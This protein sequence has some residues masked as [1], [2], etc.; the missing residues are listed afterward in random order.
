MSARDRLPRAMPKSNKVVISANSSWNLVNYRAP[1]IRALIEDGH[2]VLAAVP[3]DD[4]IPQLRALG[5]GIEPIAIQPRGLSPVGDLRLLLSYRSLMRRVAPDAFLGF[6]VKPN[7]YGTM[8]AAS[9][10]VPSINTITGLG[11]GFLSGAALQHLISTLYRAAMRKSDRVFFHNQ[12]DLD[13]F[14]GKGLIKRAQGAVVAGSGVDL[15]RF[16]AAEPPNRGTDPTF[17][18]IGRFLKDKGVGEFIEAA[19]DLRARFPSAR[20][21][22]IGSIEDHPKAI[23]RE[24]VETA[25]QQ[26]IVELI[27]TT[28][29]VRPFIADADCV[30]LPSYREGLPRV[31]LEASAMA[32]PVI[33]TDVPGCRQAVV[34]GKTGLLCDSRSASALADA[35]S[36]FAAMTAGER[37]AM[38]A[39]ARRLAEREFSEARVVDSYRDALAQAVS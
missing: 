21:Q 36:S 35:M 25:A 9:A 29:D 20:F 28:M 7:I 37:A 33:A 13:L 30:V 27:G 38:G 22:M 17:L 4:T 3:E 31:I 2:K 14:V 1:I 8:A 19:R 24:I 6:T 23:A 26:K 34:T 10:G 32:R 11:T 16:R 5:A 12:E 18:F 39:E 15:D